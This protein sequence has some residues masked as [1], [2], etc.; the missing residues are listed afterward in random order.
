M[1]YSKMLEESSFAHRKADYFWLLL[2][3]AIMLLVRS[4]YPT[5]DTAF[6]LRSHS[7]EGTFPAR[8]P[9][10]PLLPPCLRPNLPL[11][12]ASPVDPHIPVRSRD[13]LR[14]LPSNCTR[15]CRLDGKWHLESRRSGPSWMCGGSRRVVPEGCLDERDGWKTNDS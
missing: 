14:S 8:K 10:L 2:Q 6:I 15:W 9:P 4:A 13:D 1:R 3:S 12:P 5:R 11:V 7:T